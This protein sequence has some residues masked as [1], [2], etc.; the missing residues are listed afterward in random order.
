VVAHLHGGL[1]D[2]GNLVAVL[3]KMRQI[4]QYEYLR[5][6]RRIEPVVN[7]DAAAAVKM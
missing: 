6:A 3:L 5:E 2:S 1:G 4:A 7:Q